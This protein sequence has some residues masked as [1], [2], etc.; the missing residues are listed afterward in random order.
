[1]LYPHVTKVIRAGNPGKPLPP[2]QRDLVK[3]AMR[4]PTSRKA[5]PTSEE[6]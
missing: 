5:S 2:S 4:R 6:A 1:M 3:R